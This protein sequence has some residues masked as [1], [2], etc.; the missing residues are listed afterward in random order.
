LDDTRKKAGVPPYYNSPES[1]QE[2][3]PWFRASRQLHTFPEIEIT[4]IS[5]PWLNPSQ[6]YSQ[7][8]QSQN[9]WRK[10]YTQLSFS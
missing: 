8:S 9:Y 10:N 5:K 6:F 3:Q 4:I 1:S 7:K 2:W